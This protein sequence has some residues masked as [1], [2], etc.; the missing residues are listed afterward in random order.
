MDA[1]A[2]G[3]E[4][5]DLKINLN[6]REFDRDSLAGRQVVLFGNVILRTVRPGYK[7]FPLSPKLPACDAT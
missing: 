3:L 1:R 7:P 4:V 5:L 6:D 2:P